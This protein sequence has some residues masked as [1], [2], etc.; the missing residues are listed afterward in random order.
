MSG[1]GEDLADVSAVGT[2]PTGNRVTFYTDQGGIVDLITVAGAGHVSYNVA[3]PLSVLAGAKV[4][5]LRVKSDS[6][7]YETTLR[8]NN[9]TFLETGE[10]PSY[11]L[12]KAVTPFVGAEVFLWNHGS[13]DLAVNFLPGKTDQLAAAPASLT[14]RR[15]RTSVAAALRLFF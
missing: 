1:A 13:I 14:F 4:S 5:S 2:S 8:P 12:P 11:W 7:A 10:S 3:G 6:G 15:Q 9:R